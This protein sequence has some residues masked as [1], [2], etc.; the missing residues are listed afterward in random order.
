MNFKEIIESGLIE[1][2]AMNALSAAEVAQVEA[3]AAEFPEVRAEIEEAQAALELYAQAHSMEPPADMKAKIMANFEADYGDNSNKKEAEK[4]VETPQNRPLSISGENTGTG[5]TFG[6]TLPWTIAIIG[7]IAA[8]SSFWQAKNT[9][10]QLSDCQ[11][12]SVQLAKKQEI[13]VDLEGK[14]NIF[15]SGNT[16]K[17][18]LV[19]DPKSPLPKDLKVLVYWNAKD[20]ATLLSIQKLPPPGKGKQYQL[21]AIAGKDAPIAAGLI[22]YDMDLVQPMKNFDKVDVFAITLENEGGSL[23]PSLDKMYVAGAIL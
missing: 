12:E 2:Y 9:A 21:W 17:I 11:Q 19:V 13:I 18:D 20:K 7:L 1:L 10:S 8:I 14:L 6:K 23:V 5:I 4:P 16:K 22:T 15:R 3:W